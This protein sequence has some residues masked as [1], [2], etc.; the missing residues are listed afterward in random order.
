[1]KPSK[2]GI[3]LKTWYRDDIDCQTHIATI[4]CYRLWYNIMQTPP[5][6]F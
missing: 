3:I 2:V 1:M 6:W 5:D 4:S